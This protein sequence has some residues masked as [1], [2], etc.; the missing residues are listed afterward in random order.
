M[1][2]GARTT[3]LGKWTW[4]T[5]TGRS[6]TRWASRSPR[7]TSSCRSAPAPSAGRSGKNSPPPMAA[8]CGKFQSLNCLTTFADFRENSN[9]SLVSMTDQSGRSLDGGPQGSGT[10]GSQKCIDRVFLEPRTMRET[11]TL[12]W[13]TA[14][15][16]GKSIW[17]LERFVNNNA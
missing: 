14:R 2:G 5:P 7:S 17:Y 15:D 9:P 11:K 4:M 13:I 6:Q 10:Q 16:R 8:I 3:S 12:T 1:H